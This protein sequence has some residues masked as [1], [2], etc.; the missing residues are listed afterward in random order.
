MK[1]PE[2]GRRATNGLGAAIRQRRQRMSQHLS[3]GFAHVRLQSVASN[4]KDEVTITMEVR[5]AFDNHADLPGD[6]L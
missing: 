3:R 2:A 6:A 5:L 4:G 1:V